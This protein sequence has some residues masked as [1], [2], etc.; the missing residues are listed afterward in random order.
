MFTWLSISLTYQFPKHLALN[1]GINVLEGLICWPIALKNCTFDVFNTIHTDREIDLLNCLNFSLTNFISFKGWNI[2]IGPA[3]NLAN[4]DKTVAK[5]SWFKRDSSNI[6]NIFQGCFFSQS[7]S[8]RTSFQSTNNK[9][10]ENK[11]LFMF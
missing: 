3:F 6:L 9:I 7:N 1:Q 4:K 2:K 10:Y 5:F 8:C 11:Q